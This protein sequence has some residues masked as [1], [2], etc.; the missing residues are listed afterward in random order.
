MELVLD[1]AQRPT[2]LIFA[3]ERK[4]GPRPARAHMEADRGPNPTPGHE[5]QDV[6]NL[7][8]SNQPALSAH[9]PWCDVEH[10]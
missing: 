9:R 5:E 7:D 2:D 3:T 10:C 8:E 6:Q 4:G 1:A